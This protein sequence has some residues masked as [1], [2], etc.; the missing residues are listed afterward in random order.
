MT[1]PATT[2][3]RSTDHIDVFLV[4]DHPA[5]RDALTI[6]INSTKDMEVCGQSS[7]SGEAFRR[8]EL[9]K[10]EVAIVDISLN[11]GHGLEL[12]ENARAQLPEIRTIVFSMYDENVYAERA[13]RAGASGYLMKNKPLEKI[14]EAIHRVQ[15]GEV[16]LS[17]RMASKMLN[18][19]VEKNSSEPN[20]AIDRL[21]DREMAV[22]QMLGQ[23]CSVEEIQDRLNLSRKTIETYR[24]RAK[25]K[26]GFEKINELVQYAVKWTYGQGIHGPDA[27]VPTPRPPASS[28]QE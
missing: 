26:L 11:D 15:E 24:R 14:I 10:P 18:R 17:P 2:A 20:L 21:T 28:S 7:T 9:E 5:I 22:F 8:L 4:D 16:Y 19:I 23:G 25:D 13:L 1:N 27:D 12:V 3:S 6:T